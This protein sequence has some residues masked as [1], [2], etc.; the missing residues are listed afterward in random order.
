MNLVEI[1]ERDY[2]KFEEGAKTG[3][4]LQDFSRADFR[5]TLGFE[6][7]TLGVFDKED[8]KACMLL[9]VKNG[10]AMIQLGP[11]MD[12]SDLKLLKFVL[13]EISEFCRNK[14]VFVLEIFPPMLVSIRDKDGNVLE[15]FEKEAVK[16]CFADAGFEFEGETIGTVAKANRFMAVKDMSEIHDEEA[17]SKSYNYNVRRTI[18]KYGDQVYVETLKDLSKLADVMQPISDSNKRNEVNDRPVSYFEDMKKYFGDELVLQVAY[19]KESGEAVASHVFF[20]H[21]GELVSFLAGI[22]E[23]NKHLNGMTFLYDAF[24]KYA[25]E[26]KLDRAN[27]Y[28]VE[29]DFSEKNQLLRFKGHF[30]IFVEEYVGGFKKVLDE[31]AYSKANRKKKL[32]GGL[33]KIK[34]LI[35][36]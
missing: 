16:K 33:R 26:K 21:S 36:K 32:M 18:K 22:S 25:I 9:L 28:G 23:K 14:N 35:K 31:K 15:D 11:V 4:L 6:S 19:S 34:R 12:Y 13:E 3:N 24:Y 20:N 5:K 29:G 10:E 1:S 7:Y 27:L 8:L 2:R 30:G 17:L